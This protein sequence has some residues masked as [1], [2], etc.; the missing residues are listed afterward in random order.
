[1]FYSPK[2][3]Y[4][5]SSI[6]FVS[7]VTFFVKTSLIIEK[8]NKAQLWSLISFPSSAPTQTKVSIATEIAGCFLDF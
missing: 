3:P 4:F 8:E 2:V 7:F 6:P 5:L 1:M